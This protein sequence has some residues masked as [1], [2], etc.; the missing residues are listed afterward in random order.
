MI[1]VVIADEVRLF[2][3]G[4]TALLGTEPDMEMV[5]AV[6][7][8]RTVTTAARVQE[9]DVA[10]VDLELP[11]MD[12]FT[13]T[14]AVRAAAP[15]CAVLVLA[16]RRR[17]GDLRRAVAAG[18]AGF[19]MKDSSP[20]ELTDAI[21][22]VARGERVIDADLAFA[23]LVTAQPAP[24]TPRELDVL[25]VAAE[26]ATVGE[27]AER[28]HLSRGT[29]RNYLGRVVAKVGAR[30]RIEAITIARDNGWLL[31]EARSRGA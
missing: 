26:G 25:G 12:A 29:V 23:E 30:T 16:G 9:A 5:D 22:R 15:Q 19:V 21:R 3:S 1:R 4:L 31:A 10:L 17:P 7:D 2:R 14:G 8:G 18:A 6:E 20:H 28:L 13:V 24:L 11:D 27:I